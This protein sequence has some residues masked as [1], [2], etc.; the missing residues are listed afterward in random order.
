VSR[1]LVL[2][3]S[4]G[5]GHLRA[6]EAV[7]RAVTLEA[8]SAEVRQLDVLT[9]ASPAFRGAYSRWYLSLV[10]RAP[11]LWGYLYDRLDRPAKRR[12]VDL[13]RALNHWNTR[14]LRQAVR[15]F[16]PDAV[17][18]THFLPAEVLGEAR[19]KG[20]LRARLG[21]V[22]TDADVHR[23]WMHVGVDRYFVARPEAGALLEAAGFAA[24]RVEATGIPVDP[25]FATARDRVQVRARLDLPAAGPVV[26]LLAGGF[27]VGPVRE[28]AS[29]LAQARLPA[30]VVVVA[31]R[32]E[33]LRR[34]LAAA[35]GPRTRVLGFS[36]EIHEWMAAADL[37]VTK[38][39]GLTTA[40]ALVRGL[41][42]VLVNPIPGQEERNADAL[43]EDGVAVKAG[44]PELLAWKVDGLLADAGR[45]AAMRAAARRS[46]RP[47]ASRRVARWALGA[48]L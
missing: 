22:V 29:R 11:A 47:D 32:N 7:A 44:H 33:P 9:L 42:M 30:R 2:S 19:R 6:A 5:A 18:C 12:P 14:R 27:G 25:A 39:G 37:L 41:P 34:A 35:A 26:L 15:D 21:V 48:S 40:E 20:R 17:V 45:L 24:E 36:R 3:A 46:A 31:G 1:V 38:P 4:A 16:A 23:L 8:P 43:L 13:R 10:E 28:M